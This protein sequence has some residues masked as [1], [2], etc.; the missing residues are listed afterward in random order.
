M[1]ITRDGDFCQV[2]FDWRDDD[3]ER[4]AHD[5]LVRLI[6]ATD[7][8]HDDGDLTAYL[9]ERGDDGV[10]RLSLRL[11]AGFRT[12]YQFCPVRDEPL[13]GGH[14]DDDR[15]AAILTGGHP[16]PGHGAGI[17][18][19]TWPNYGQASVLSLPDAPAQPWVEPGGAPCGTLTR[20]TLGDSAIWVYAPAVDA[21]EHAL[22]VLFDGK[23]WDGIGVTVAF[24]NLHA[25]GVIPPTVVV[26]VDSIHGLPRNQALTRPGV[27]RS[28][29]LDELLP[30]VHKGWPVT[31]DPA[32]TVLAGQS[33]GGLAAVRIG[34]DHPDRFGRVLTQSGSFW[35]AADTP[36]EIDSPALFDAYAD[37]DRV[38]LRIFQEAGSLERTLLTRNRIFHGIL[39]DRGIPVTYREY[40]GGHDYACWRGGLADGLIDL[41]GEPDALP[42]E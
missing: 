29:L 3:P 42:A 23:V 38:P 31:A 9:M 41:L 33:L 28:F 14:P 13:R 12:S 32:R 21:A 15:W 5:V 25:A 27:L 22:A 11:P 6:G 40:Q 35:R 7:Y 30:F 4:P 37:A 36:D 18:P 19:S 34:F 8:A 26:G 24:D 1:L 17:G 20:H 39:L 10:W 2:D 16:D